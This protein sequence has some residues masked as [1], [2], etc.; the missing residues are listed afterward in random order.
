MEHSN[1][2]CGCGSEHFAEGGKVKKIIRRNLPINKTY[3]LIDA[4]YTGGITDN[5]DFCE[6]CGRPIAN[7]GVIQDEEGKTYHVGMDC[8]ETLSSIKSSAEFSMFETD[9]KEATAFRTKIKNLLKKYPKAI[10]HIENTYYGTINIRVVDEVGA[11]LGS[12]SYPKEFV[13]KYLPD[14]KLKISNPEKNNFHPR[15]EN[16]YDFNFNFR[17]FIDKQAT[18]K[19]FDVEDYH[20]VVSRKDLTYPNPSGTMITNNFIVIETT[21]KGLPVNTEQTYTPG[22]V[23]RNI[24]A[25]IN[26]YEFANYSENEKFE[27]GGEL[28]GNFMPL[29][30][31]EIVG[32]KWA[33]IFP[34]YK[35]LTPAHYRASLKDYH[36]T[37]DRLRKNEYKRVNERTQDKNTAL[38][39]EKFLTEI[40][41]KAS[42]RLNNTGTIIGFEEQFAEGGPIRFEKGSKLTPEQKK[43]VLKTM[44]DSYKVLQRP[45]TIEDTPKG[46]RR[47]WLENSYDY[48]FKSGITGQNIRWIVQLP[49]NTYAHPSELYPSITINDINR[50][51][52]NRQ[53]TEREIEG[54][55]QRWLK[56]LDYNGSKPYLIEAIKRGESSNNKAYTEYNDKG[57]VTDSGFDNGHFRQSAKK[58]VSGL[59]QDDPKANYLGIKFKDIISEKTGGQDTW[60]GSYYES[61]DL[62]R[63]KR[64]FMSI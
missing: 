15:F 55:Y 18:P 62:L 63:F 2:F 28:K 64:E 47:V 38:H 20:I 29:P 51:E 54:D 53:I 7:V 14:Y 22:D 61:P 60:L 11:Y 39:K 8:A 19:E 6:N 57:Q 52:I 49:D 41:Y 42:I 33:D 25:S 35:H 34:K 24:I 48:M 30:F 4:Y 59:F 27:E 50:E 9:F 26:K 37:I 43:E 16:N 23:G 21:K 10:I 1:T 40:R 32:K 12:F 3:K 58:F 13:F 31:S 36:A 46:E 5:P 44:R 17:H 45:Y 56:K